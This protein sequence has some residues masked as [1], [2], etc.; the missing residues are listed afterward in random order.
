LR[1]DAK[2][3]LGQL[4]DLMRGRYQDPDRV[5]VNTGVHFTGGEPFLNFDLL[6]ELT[7]MAEVLGI[8]RTFVETNC[9]WCRDDETTHDRLTQLKEAGLKGILVSANPFVIE[10]VPFERI[11]RGAKISEETFGSNAIVYQQFFFHQFMELGIQGTLPFEQYVQLRGE[12]L[13]YAELLPGGRFSYGLG[14]YFRS[15]PANSFFRDSCGDELLRD[16]HVHIDN[17]CNYVP[18]YCAGISWGDARDIDALCQ[19]VDLGRL[20]V[21]NALMT[22]IGELY[23]LGKDYG[24]QELDGYVSKC[25]LCVDIRRHLVSKDEFMELQPTEFYDHL[26]V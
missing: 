16:W 20:P 6:L 1:E 11:A 13:R 21:L 10:S 15:R 14:S 26:E 22:S 3:I 2:R 4:A 8:P 9:F 17:Y 18:G 7:E 23:R 25:H 5:G 24:Y 12:G 19:G